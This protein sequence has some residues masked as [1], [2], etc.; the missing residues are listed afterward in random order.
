MRPRDFRLRRR[1]AIAIGGLG[2]SE[3]L[4][5]V[6]TK[7]RS[8]DVVEVLSDSL[9]ARSSGGARNRVRAAASVGQGSEL[10]KQLVGE[11]RSFFAAH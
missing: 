7:L 3:R 5:G 9:L 8:N 4:S 11:R 2:Q 10:A 6:R 1:R